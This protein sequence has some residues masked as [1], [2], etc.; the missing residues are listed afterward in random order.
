[1]EWK[2]GRPWRHN[3]CPFN[4]EHKNSS[5]IFELNTGALVFKCLHNSCQ[6]RD[7][8]DLRNLVESGCP[9][10]PSPFDELCCDPW[11]EPVLLATPPPASLRTDDLPGVLG[12]FASALSR[13][14][15]TPADLSI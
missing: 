3:T 13:H 10:H 11:Q 8:R 5:A 9:N 2:D 15:E 12:E 6:Q 14:T 1:V 4:P 7:W